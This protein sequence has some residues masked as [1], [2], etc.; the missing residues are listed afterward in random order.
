MSTRSDFCC[1]FKLPKDQKNKFQVS[2]KSYLIKII[3]N[4]NATYLISGF[5]QTVESQI[6][7]EKE[8][9][10]SFFDECVKFGYLEESVNNLLD[11]FDS[12]KNDIDLTYESIE[13]YGSCE[14][15]D[16]NRSNTDESQLFIRS[17]IDGIPETT[18]ITLLNWLDDIIL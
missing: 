10:F 4:P 2:F 1:F 3:D 15:N 7:K 16:F 13:L 6:E 12:I 8:I 9:G 14:F 11:F 17:E 5:Y 18:D